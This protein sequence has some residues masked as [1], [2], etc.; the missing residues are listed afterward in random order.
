ME[1]IDIFD[2]NGRLLRSHVK[3][4]EQLGEGEFMRVVG[5]WIINT[6]RQILLTQRA[7]AKSFA[8]GKWENTG[9]HLLS[10]ENSVT[11][12]L[13]ELREETG[14]IAEPDELIFLGNAV[15]PPY[16]GENFVII[17]NISPDEI[18]LQ[19]G[20]TDDVKWVSYEEFLRM[21]DEN[22]LAPSVITH[23]EPNLKRFEQFFLAQ[24]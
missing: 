2:E 17:R 19:E 5:C 9:G 14:I 6:E 21:A 11:G 15:V 23:L 16:L 8:P 3:R 12:T 24:D 10:G 18:K 1:Y 20:E 13:R 7:A 22:E 4:G